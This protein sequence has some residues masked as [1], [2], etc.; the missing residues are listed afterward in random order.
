MQLNV[1][2]R[3][4]A[5]FTIAGVFPSLVFAQA[6]PGPRFQE[7]VD[8][9]PVQANLQRAHR[10]FQSFAARDGGNWGARFDEAS[11]RP[12]M[13]YGTGI[14]VSATP[15]TSMTAAEAAATTVLSQFP[16]LWGT[17]LRYLELTNKVKT[18]PLYIFTWNQKFDG[19]DVRGA[20]VQIQVHETGRVAALVA[21]GVQI[22]DG[23][24]RIPKLGP[25]DA[26]TT[27]RRLKTP[28]SGDLLGARDFLVYVQ[29]GAGT[30]VPKLAYK[31]EV[32]QPWA[33]VYEDVFVDAN[34]GTILE[35][36]PRRYNITDVKG[37]VTGRL[38]TSLSSLAAPV[39]GVPLANVKVTVAGVGTAITDANGDYLITTGLAGPFNVSVN[40]NGNVFNVVPAQGGAVSA[41]GVTVNISGAE[42]AD[43]VLNPSPTEFATS[44]TT[45]AYHHNLINDYTKAE[46]P[47]YTGFPAQTV[48]VN[49]ANTCN[50][51][52]SLGD[53][54]IN[55][56][57]A[58]GSCG[59]TAYST[60]IYHEFG[61]GVD[62]FFGG[63]SSGSL[64]EG[65]GDVL[66]I[67]ASGQPI[68]GQDFLGAGNHIRTGENSTSWPASECGGE[69][70]C[71]G[72]TYMG[73]AWQAY[74][75]LQI[76][77]GAAAG[78]Q[79]A[80]TDFLG[81]IPADSTSI[82]NAVT[83]VFIVDDNDADLTNGT[84]HYADLAAAAIMKG[85]TPPVIA[86]MA[87]IHSRHPDTFNQSQPYAIYA[88][89]T[90]L[91]PN[92]VASAFVDYSVDGGS[93][94]TVAMQTTS[95]PNEYVGNIPAVAGPKLISYWI[96]S[97]DSIA[98]TLTRPTGDDAY[99][100]AV[101]RKTTLFSDNLDSGAPGWT[102]VLVVKN[103][104]WQLGT[105]QTAGTNAY[106][107]TSA[108]SG[109]NCWGTDLQLT[110]SN[111]NY[112]SNVDNYLETPNI[113]AS[114]F[115]GVRLRFR[116]WLSV[117]N[118]NSDQ[119]TLSVNG[120]QVY[121]NPSSA[122][123]FD[124]TWTLQDHA[125]PA[126]N[127]VASFKARWRIDSNGS[128]QYG[129]W[130]VDDVEVYSLEATPVVNFNI[131]PVATSIP[132]GSNLAFN[133]NGTPN[134]GWELYASLDGGPSALEGYGVI[135]AG[136]GTIAYFTGGDL[137]PAGQGSFVFGIPN[138]AQL[139]GLKIW[140]VG[141]A[142][143]GASLPQISNTVVTEFTP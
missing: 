46:I 43:L 94:Q 39:P 108:Y 57:A 124:S 141:G 1:L 40:L 69:I 88:T 9:P 102:H 117:Q 85:F 87:Q 125:A 53:N 143:A 135:G 45:G 79:V 65:V 84:P 82:L 37:K 113:N 114:G 104:E 142:V 86:T 115:T 81:A 22:P 101:G 99:R 80:E 127:N 13:I 5:V 103:D 110:G 47:S 70:H 61:H 3:V 58:G 97:I 136:T 139:V 36:A 8:H 119:A 98:N 50:A 78:A 106:D 123:L 66:A 41:A 64:S 52:Y 44:Q 92:T 29:T 138:D 122:S 16:E 132:V 67:L 77:L 121:I 116:R 34:D 109:N 18:G 74:K 131:T 24:S 72:E 54:S 118:S 28:K 83:Q 25:E 31:V 56:Y 42:V 26:E 140:W 4:S 105:P 91:S 90:A 23:F 71:V 10:G 51:V 107:P 49:I 21:E 12:A 32:E 14:A 128:T 38:N 19:L 96:R 95:I 11:G 48:N 129:G 15:I 60:V 130:N 20:R 126:A 93:I 137:D 89:I 133:F 55:F 134:A 63:I 35:V 17:E 62:D 100:F 30:A 7:P 27:V 33:D 59:N 111:G 112:S 75:K 76:S 68:I 120:S 73:F 2:S 6:T